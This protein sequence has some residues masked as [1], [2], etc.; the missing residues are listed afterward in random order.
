[1]DYPL[2]AAEGSFRRRDEL[3]NIMNWLCFAF[4]IVSA[5]IMDGCFLN[6]CPY[7][8]YGRTIPC[9]SCGEFMNFHRWIL[10]NQVR[11]V[12]KLHE[13]EDEIII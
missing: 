12:F 4:L 8:R 10:N 11:N 6:S 2:R 5:N 1:M 7:R 9:E 13:P 3:F